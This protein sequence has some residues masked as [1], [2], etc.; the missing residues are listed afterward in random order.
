MVLIGILI[1]VLL[2][3]IL[4]HDTNNG[5]TH[6]RKLIKTNTSNIIIKTDTNN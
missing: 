4:K 6:I 1:T 2:T 3:Y 5:N